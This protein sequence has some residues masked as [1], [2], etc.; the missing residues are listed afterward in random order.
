MTD[1]N[2]LLK[3]GFALV[4]QFTNVVDV[5]PWAA[6]QST[7]DLEAFVAGDPHSPVD[8]FLMHKKGSYFWI[9]DGVVHGYETPGSYFCL[10]DPERITNFVGIAQLSSNQVL[11]LA[12]A[13]VRRLVKS[14]DPLANQSPIV[15]TASPYHGKPVP[16]YRFTWPST[17]A[18]LPYAAQIEIDARKSRVVWLKLMDRNFFDWQFA[19]QISNRVYTADP[20]PRAPP[21]KAAPR[22]APF[23]STNQVLEAIQKWLWVCS[24]LG[25]I[26]GSQTNLAD[27]D[28]ER[29]GLYIWPRMSTNEHVCRVS[30][31]NGALFDSFRGYVIDWAA[32]DKC[33][34]NNWHSR[35]AEDWKPFKGKVSRRW[36]DLAKNFNALL[37]KHFGFSADFLS[38]LNVN[39][40]F[41][42]AGE[43]TEPGSEGITRI[44][45]AWRQFPKK[46]RRAD[47]FISIEETK[48]MMMAEFDL[49]SG[50][51]KGF[52]I[53]DRKFAELFGRSQLQ[54]H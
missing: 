9:R 21:R 49:Q 16:F 45:V 42:I 54:V 13:T 25:T 19:Q 26:P 17:N 8:L 53:Y 20:K 11:E 48:L 2:A 33:F 29:T 14:G 52:T 41:V 34:T 18:F 43:S 30:L 47:G 15:E 44:E 28:W 39:P 4:A 6:P 22:G 1:V 5:P 24:Q 50:E 23:P 36:Q 51:L 35:S 37:V 40:A 46:S 10:Q 27:V 7:N 12:T 38:S 3:I 32:A 31:T